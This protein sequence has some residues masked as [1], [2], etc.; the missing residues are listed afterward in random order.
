MYVC[1][2]HVSQYFSIHRDILV[3]VRKILTTISCTSW[4][5]VILRIAWES[6]RS[7]P[8]I[9]LHLVCDSEKSIFQTAKHQPYTIYV[10]LILL[11]EYYEEKL[12]QA[13][14]TCATCYRD[15]VIHMPIYDIYIEREED[16]LSFR[17]TIQYTCSSSFVS[18]LLFFA[19]C[20]DLVTD[21]VT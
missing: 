12:V 4:P 8:Q 15:D 17:T 5:S 7:Y 19:R 9:P 11:S 20:F 10:V 14:S 13:L 3:E 18:N 6:M 1:V 2:S 21:F 16:L